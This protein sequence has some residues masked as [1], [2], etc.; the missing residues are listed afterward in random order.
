MNPFPTPFILLLIFALVNAAPAAT[1]QI[2]RQKSKI[3]VQVKSTL[4]DFSGTLERYE[5]SIAFNPK[6]SV[7]AKVDLTFDFKDLDTGDKGRDSDMLKWLAYTS[8]PH[9]SFHLTGWKQD[10]SQFSA[11][12]ELSLHGVSKEIRI[13]VTIEK[14][15]ETYDIKGTAGLDYRDFQLP[16]IRKVMVLTVDPHL[17]VQFH[18]VGKAEPAR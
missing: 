4:H 7:P 1:L 10:G 6:T 17:T 13:S 11:R 9:A 5:L 14:D 12:G 15:G 3:E 2:D 18:L 16:L 8:N